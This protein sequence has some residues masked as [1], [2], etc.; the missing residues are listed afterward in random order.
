MDLAVIRRKEDGDKVKN[1]R[2]LSFQIPEDDS[3]ACARSF[4]DAFMLANKELFSIENTGDAAASEKCA[5][6][7]A[8]EIG[9]KS[10]A[11]FA[12]EY[13]IEKK[14][15]AVP[16]YIED[17]LLWL[18]TPIEPVKETNGDAE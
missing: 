4:E 7:R 17:G 11:D 5:F 6:E 2:R 12:I 16:K 13:A 8:Q 3:G 1:Q 10:K 18:A 9:A 14:E 15:W